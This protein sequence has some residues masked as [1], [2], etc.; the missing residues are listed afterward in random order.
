MPPSN[1]NTGEFRQ[2]MEKGIKVLNSTLKK[3]STESTW[4]KLV[5]S[6]KAETLKK[7]V[8]S[9][10][11]ASNASLM[12]ESSLHPI[13][14]I[15]QGYSQTWTMRKFGAKAVFSKEM[16][17]YAQY[18]YGATMLRQLRMSLT[19]LYEVIYAS[20]LE[21]G[22]D[23]MAGG[24][25]PLLGGLSIIRSEGGDSLPLFYNAH[26]YRHG[27]PTWS[28][29][30]NGYVTLDDEGVQ[31]LYSQTRRWTDNVGRPLN[32][33]MRG[34]VIPPEMNGRW[35]KTVF[36]EKT[37]DNANNALNPAKKQIG[38][39]CIEHQWL[40]SDED[41]YV[42][43]DAEPEDCLQM[44]DGWRNEITRG[45]LNPDTGDQFIAIDSLFGHGCL[46]MRQMIK[47]TY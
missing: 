15:A 28:N 35:Y 1:G 45:E 19:T 2:W 9:Y 16:Q 11:N 6:E 22:D 41:Y 39:E 25:I 42:L 17:R 20:Y 29:I 47:V 18:D 44:H 21:Y 32:Y 14:N 37:P 23:T 27:G 43:L 30:S 34:V 13:I 46:A 4:S 3:M 36:S 8:T 26:T 40:G 7:R 12:P 33:T 38:R 5:K 10:E 24:T 31:T